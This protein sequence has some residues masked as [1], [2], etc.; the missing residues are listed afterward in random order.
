MVSAAIITETFGEPAT[1]AA[2]AASGVNGLCLPVGYA[3]WLMMFTDTPW[4]KRI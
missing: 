4:T 1:P 3:A 2:V